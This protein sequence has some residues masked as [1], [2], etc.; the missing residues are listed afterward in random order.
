MADVACWID[1]ADLIPLA[2]NSTHKHD[3]ENPIGRHHASTGRFLDGATVVMT[4]FPDLGNR[5]QALADF[6][7]GTNRQ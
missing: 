3:G 5:Q 7:T 4:F 6:Q 1:H 2:E